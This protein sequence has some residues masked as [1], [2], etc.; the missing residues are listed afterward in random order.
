LARLPLAIVLAVVAGWVDASG[1]LH[2][3]HV[4][5]SFMSG[6]STVLGIAIGQGAWHQA[7][8]PSMAMAAF[9]FGSFVGSLVRGSA[10]YWRASLLLSLEAALLLLVLLLPRSGGALAPSIV[11]LAV[12]M[13]AQNAVMREVGG[14]RITLTYVTGALVNLGH[15][16]A[17]ACLRRDR[18]SAWRIHG[19][20]WLALIAGGTGGAIAYDRFELAA[21][22][23]PLVALAMLAIVETLLVLSRPSTRV[24]DT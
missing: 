24:T 2:F 20:I 11:P 22:T 9:V 12:A 1:Y 21:L 3:A 19:S 6:N 5:V 23:V 18:P 16:L 10:T 14:V 7:L 4:F 17:K 13:G 8:S 15:S